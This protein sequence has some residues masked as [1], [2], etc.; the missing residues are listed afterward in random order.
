MHE[1]AQGLLLSTDSHTAADLYRTSIQQFFQYRRAL[2][3]TVKAIIE[4]DGDF[5][6]AHCLQGYLFMLFATDRVLGKVA[7]ALTKAETLAKSASAREQAHIK[8]LRLWYDGMT[9]EAGA[10]WDDILS[11]YPHDILALRLHHA[12]A[13]WMGRNYLLRDGVARVFPAWD[14][15]L[16]GY[17]YVL[18]MFAF[19]LEE[20]G[21]YRQAERLGKSAVERDPEDLWAI[22]AVAH[23]LEMEGRLKEGEEWLDYPADR[24]EDR[25][26]FRGHLWWHRALF[27]LE[28][29][30]YEETLALYDRSIHTER[31][32]FYLDIQNQAAILLRLELQGIN[33]GDRWQD[34]AKDLEDRIDDHAL[35]FTDL[36]CALAL[37]AAERSTSLD[38]FFQSLQAFS[39]SGNRFTSIVADKAT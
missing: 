33:V 31:T 36:H 21:D 13:F 10:L 25:N 29:G 12:N 5:A 14:E 1:D 2:G 38:A 7:A 3:G 16:S 30:R 20:C 37:A 39:T 8:A 23:V 11:E 17:S 15:S 27:L 32:D 22:H 18:G 26:P 19:G 35:A 34:L 6:M 24:W 9:P 28:Q 4:A